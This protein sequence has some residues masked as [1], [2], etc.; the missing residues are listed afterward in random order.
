MAFLS[1]NMIK[2]LIEFICYLGFKE[3]RRF[4]A[5]AGGFLPGLGLQDLTLGLRTNRK[6]IQPEFK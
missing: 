2:G 6:T 1:C 5:R 4:V 3:E